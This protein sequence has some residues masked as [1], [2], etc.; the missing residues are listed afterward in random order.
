MIHIRGDYL[1]ARAFRLRCSVLPFK[2]ARAAAHVDYYAVLGGEEFT[3][4]HGA[5]T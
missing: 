2:I 5:T 4:G 1:T 3:V